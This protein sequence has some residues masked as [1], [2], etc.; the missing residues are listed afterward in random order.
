[1]L[2]KTSKRKRA[3][4]AAAVAAPLRRVLSYDIGIRNLAET[5]LTLEG[6]RDYNVEHWA[7]VDILAAS[8]SRAHNSARV[9]TRQLLAAL[10]T[11]LCAALEHTCAAPLDAILLEQQMRG[12]AKL[13]TVASA[14][15]VFYETYY[16]SARHQPPPPILF[17]SAKGKLRVFVHEPPA[18]V[19]VTQRRITDLLAPAHSDTDDSSDDG[20][21]DAS[22]AE[23]KHTGKRKCAPAS[24]VPAPES[25]SAAYRKRKQHAV[26]ECDAFLREFPRC[27]HWLPFYRALG[28]KRDDVADSLLQAVYYLKTSN[29]RRAAL[30]PR[31]VLCPPA[32]ARTVLVLSDTD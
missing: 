12:G 23:E 13:K 9:P 15:Q 10:V 2:A 32:P 6:A 19:V 22:S 24:D 30:P 27:T 7:R 21:H 11:H 14:I 3:Q 29:V 18:C 17:L 28:A 20:S 1:M 26:R 31:I 8:G 5:V 25:E 16:R 4:A